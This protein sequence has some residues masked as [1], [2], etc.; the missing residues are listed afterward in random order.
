MTD[1]HMAEVGNLRPG[2]N[3]DRVNM[4]R[5]LEFLSSKIELKSHQNGTP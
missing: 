2:K 5:V 1:R 4:T 3:A